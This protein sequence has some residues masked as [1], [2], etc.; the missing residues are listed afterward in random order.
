M[1]ETAKHER[2]L[3]MREK[4]KCETEGPRRRAKHKGE[5]SMREKAKCERDSY[6]RERSKHEREG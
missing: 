2:E 6:A 4:A 3:T 1:R 5:L